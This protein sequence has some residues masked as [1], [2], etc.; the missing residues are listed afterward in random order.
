MEMKISAERHKKIVK[1][2]WNKNREAEE[3]IET[4]G[5]IGLTCIEGKIGS[6]MDWAL[7]MFLMLSPEG[8]IEGMNA[9]EEDLF[10]NEFLYGEVFEGFYE[11]WF[12]EEEAGDEEEGE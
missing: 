2:L 8:M 9:K 6:A 4:L 1:L 3:V 12:S 5:E 11:K 10:T 7:T